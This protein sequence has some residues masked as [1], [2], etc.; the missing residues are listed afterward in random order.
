M[1]IYILFKLSNC[2]FRKLAVY[3]EDTSLVIHVALD[4]LVVISEIS[5][6]KKLLRDKNLIFNLM[7]LFLLGELCSSNNKLRWKPLLLIVPLRLGLA[8]INPLYIPGIQVSKTMSLIDFY[9][10]KLT[11]A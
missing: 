11:F 3:D 10:H 8:N 2:V 7:T 9:N 5:K 6:Y 4:N 1:V